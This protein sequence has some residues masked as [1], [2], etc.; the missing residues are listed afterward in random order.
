MLSLLSK[1]TKVNVLSQRKR[2]EV[3]TEAQKR[4]SEN[5]RIVGLKEIEI[6]I[7]Y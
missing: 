4:L 6:C 7:S 5:F 3:L 2:K 1:L